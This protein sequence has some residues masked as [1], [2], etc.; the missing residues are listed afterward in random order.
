MTTLAII[1]GTGLA[2]TE[3]VTITR[4]EMV[5]TPYGAPSCPLAFGELAGKP[6]VFLARHG[7]T[8]NIQ[9]HQINYCAN[10]WALKSVGV[11]KV[12]AVTAVRGIAG[13]A[14]CGKIAIPD[15]VIDY[16]HGRINSFFDGGTDDAVRQI[17]FSEPYDRVLRSELIAAAQDA[18]IDCVTEGTYGAT[19][20]PRMETIA[21]IRVLERD[22][23]TMAGMTG[24]PEASLAREL[25]L[26]YAS[27]AVIAADAAGKGKPY[28][29]QDVKANLT[30]G[31]AS[32]R[33]L[34]AN[35]LPRLV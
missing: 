34:L 30:Q 10:I 35:C 26:A 19:E 5:K 9:P 18:S 3:G 6:M 28:A 23:C 15:Q 31:M 17:D 25:D 21:E 2:L 33:S 11:E 27:C 13:N 32:V 7:N 1:G 8:H 12:I 14:A 24:M 20:G 16:T 22:G 29:E 4:R